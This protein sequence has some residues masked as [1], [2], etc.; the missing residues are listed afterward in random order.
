MAVV[1]VV[2]WSGGCGGGQGM[3]RIVASG[4]QMLGV[5]VRGIMLS[6]KLERLDGI[7]RDLIN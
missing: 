2:G 6:P 3:R 1:V 5:E 4:Y 7:E